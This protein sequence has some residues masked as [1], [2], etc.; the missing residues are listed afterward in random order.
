ME[1]KL[2]DKANNQILDSNGLNLTE[3]FGDKI[4]RGQFK[5]L[6]LRIIGN[7]FHS[8]RGKKSIGARHGIERGEK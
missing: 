4:H 5:E 2:T 3:R 7:G 8:G 1:N 6:C